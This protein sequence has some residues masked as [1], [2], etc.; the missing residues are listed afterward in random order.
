[1]TSEPTLERALVAL[2]PYFPRLVI[3]GGTAIGCSRCTL[4]LTA[5]DVETDVPVTNPMT[6][7]VQKL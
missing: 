3:I 4:S 1:M 7:V 6:Y 2:A 5:D